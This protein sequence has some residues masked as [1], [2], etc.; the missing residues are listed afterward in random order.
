VKKPD[1]PLG[2]YARFAGFF[3]FPSIPFRTSLKGDVGQN[4]SGKTEEE[5]RVTILPEK[6]C[7]PEKNR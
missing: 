1:L 4:I 5:T 3:A 6:T 7:Q 2:L